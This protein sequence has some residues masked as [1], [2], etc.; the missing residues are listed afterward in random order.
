MSR[1]TRSCTQLSRACHIHA[2]CI[3]RARLAH[4]RHVDRA[5]HRSRSDLLGLASRLNTVKPLYHSLCLRV[6]PPPRFLTRSALRSAAIWLYASFSACLACT[7]FNVVS[8]LHEHAASRCIADREHET[9]RHCMCV[10][11]LHASFPSTN[12]R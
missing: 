1:S 2:C 5:R 10:S 12:P 6:K 8:W 11:L 9:R 3:D 7:V 4:M